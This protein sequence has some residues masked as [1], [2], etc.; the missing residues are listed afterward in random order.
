MY[1]LPCLYGNMLSDYC[2]AVQESCNIDRLSSK[3]F[4]RAFKNSEE[5]PDFKVITE[6]TGGATLMHF[7][8][9]LH[10]YVDDPDTFVVVVAGL[11]DL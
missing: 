7:Y 5:L 8:D 1:Y 3:R 11:C 2:I 6:C 10:P 4:R 9:L